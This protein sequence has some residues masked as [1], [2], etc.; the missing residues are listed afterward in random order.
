MT[1]NTE[2]ENTEPQEKRSVAKRLIPMIILIACFAVAETLLYL[3]ALVQIIW[4]A[5]DGEP[6]SRISAFSASLAEWLRR[7]ARYLSFVTEDK[8]F[9]WDNWPSQPEA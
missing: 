6:N 1:E 8:P 2:P 9:P 5:V 7:N 4:T 3:I